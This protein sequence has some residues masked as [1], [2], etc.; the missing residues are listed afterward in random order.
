MTNRSI[1]ALLIAVWMAG[2]A[3]SEEFVL[4]GKM[5]FNSD[6]HPGHQY[7]VFLLQEGKLSWLGDYHTP[8]LSPDG[9]LI[10]ARRLDGK[11]VIIMDTAG[12]VQKSIDIDGEVSG[13]LW[14]PDGKNI[15]A[16]Q[17]RG[18][19][20]GPALLMIDIASSQIRV[21]YEVQAGCSMTYRTISPDG[22]RVLFTS[23]GGSDPKLRQVVDGLYLLDIE[24]LRVEKIYPYLALCGMWLPD[25]KHIAFLSSTGV[26][27]GRVSGPH[28][29]L[30]VMNI[31]TK[32]VRKLHDMSFP[33][34][35]GIKI[36]KDGKYFYLAKGYDHGGVGIVLLPVDDPTKEIRVTYPVKNWIDYSNDTK[37]DWW[38]GE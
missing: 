12:V 4:P 22:R 20:T 1:M 6:R 10:T 14:T 7:G 19:G 17:Y 21:L 36:S 16:V 34:M 5:V 29:S 9:K 27:G 11:Q 31:E 18:Q 33:A 24:S 37:P 23:S 30:W 2:C 8:A 32:Q 15:I 35:D 25:G 38:Q 26:D 3:S 28:A 13:P